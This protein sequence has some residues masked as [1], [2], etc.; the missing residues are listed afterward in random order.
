M[1]ASEHE[2]DKLQNTY[3]ARARAFVIAWLANRGIKT[4]LDTRSYLDGQRIDTHA[5]PE[6]TDEL[7]AAANQAGVKITHYEPQ[8][9]ETVPPSTL[10]IPAPTDD[11]LQ[12]HIYTQR[13]MPAFLQARQE[14]AVLV[15]CLIGCGIALCLLWGFGPEWFT[16]S[17]LPSD[18]VPIPDL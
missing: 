4:S 1:A 16:P 8:F 12:H 13:N 5:N 2:L 9:S 17:V 11:Q 7:I 10:M 6:L 15:I 18:A 3:Y 14:L